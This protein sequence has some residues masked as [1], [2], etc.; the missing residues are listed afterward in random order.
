MEE[1]IKNQKAHIKNLENQSLKKDKDQENQLPQKDKD[2][3]NQLAKI[4]DLENQLAQKDKVWTEKLAQR[5]KDYLTQLAQK[6][7]DCL[8]MLAKITN[9]KNQFEQKEV[10]LLNLFAS[11]DLKSLKTSLNEFSFCNPETRGNF[12]DFFNNKMN[13]CSNLP[14]TDSENLISQPES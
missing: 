9:L 7:R 5:Y 8:K 12:I 1:T 11:N 13:A 14:W 4:K 3:E 10:N 6:D 2:H